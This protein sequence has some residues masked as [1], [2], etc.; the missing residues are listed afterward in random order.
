MNQD[1]NKI[2]INMLNLANLTKARCE[3]FLGKHKN[4]LDTYIYRYHGVEFPSSF[5]FFFLNSIS[6]SLLPNYKMSKKKGKFEFFKEIDHSHQNNFF[7]ILS[8]CSDQSVKERLIL[9]CLEQHI[10]TLIKISNFENLHDQ[11]ALLNEYIEM[12]VPGYLDE[13]SYLEEYQLSEDKNFSKVHVKRIE[14]YQLMVNSI[15]EFFP[16]LEILRKYYMKNFVA[17]HE[18]FKLPILNSGKEVLFSKDFVKRNL[19]INKYNDLVLMNVHED[20]MADTFNKDDL[21]LIIKFNGKVLSKLLDNGIYALNM[22]GKIIIRRL[23]FLELS[24]RT[25]VNIIS[26]NKKYSDQQVPYD[27]INIYGEVVWKCNNFKDI[28]F[29]KYNTQEQNLFSSKEDYEIPSFLNNNYSK[30]EIA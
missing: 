17:P 22:N 11:D 27:E 19:N 13:I 20:N 18:T 15:K 5:A 12:I 23:Q 24:K 30:K 21:A 26:D 1:S 6:T 9:P 25:L 2:L 14:N 3:Q 7:K 10:L 4:S 28:Q 29:N 16:I 8:Q